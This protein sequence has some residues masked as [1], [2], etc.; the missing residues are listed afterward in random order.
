ME[1]FRCR[2][3]LVDERAMVRVNVGTVVVVML[4]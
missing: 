4:A 3:R 2:G 1:H